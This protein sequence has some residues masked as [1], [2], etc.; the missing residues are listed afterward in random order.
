MLEALPLAAVLMLSPGPANLATLALTSRHGLRCVGP[1]LI[2][3]A[4]GY[5]AVAG[6]IAVVGSHYLVGSVG[7]QTAVS[8]AGGVF[9]A[10]LGWG[11]IARAGRWTGAEP[12]PG[13]GGGLTLQLL[14]PKFPAVVLSVLAT[15]EGTNP[16]PAIATL[17]AAGVVGLGA[18]ATL[19]AV[20]KRLTH[21]P[22]SR[23][24]CDR[25]FGLLLVLTGSWLA[26]TPFLGPALGLG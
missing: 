8:V 14:N 22:T 13:L 15:G 7:L 20:A 26:A 3:I 9:V 11:L 4:V 16:W 1:F 10:F 5:V 25:V 21:R 18:Y 6:V 17:I 23:L 24:W 2:G 19:G 12:S